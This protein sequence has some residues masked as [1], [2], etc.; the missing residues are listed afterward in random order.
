MPVTQNSSAVN[1]PLRAK[2]GRRSP[3]VLS[4]QLGSRSLTIGLINNMPDAA[5]EATER[6]FISLL[7]A[8]SD[9]ISIRLILYAMPG[10]PRNGFGTQHI[11]KYYCSTDSLHEEK[12]DALIVTGRE[13]LTANLADESYWTSF[14]Q[15]L[16]WA[17][18][19][20]YAVV[21]SCLAAHA[22]VLHMDGVRRVRSERKH[23]GILECRRADE[24][25]LTLGSGRRFAV[26]HSRW[27]GLPEAELVERGYG[28]LSRTADAGVD[29]FYKP[30]KS[31]FLFFQGH[32]EY[33]SMTLLLEYRRDVTRYL[34]AES[35]T[36]PSVPRNYFPGETERALN[37][38]E[39]I[40][41]ESRSE[42]LL[43]ELSRILE[44]TAIENSWRQTGKKIY[45]NWLDY[46]CAQK[47]TQLPA[48]SRPNDH[49]GLE[50]T[51]HIE[52][53]EP[54]TQTSM[55]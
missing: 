39:E 44:S 27:N 37:A 47:R 36:Y 10:V 46:I 3:A 31:L 45:Q 28:V 4:D 43:Q 13:P 6:Q 26:P 14:T 34:R 51:K 21:W 38:L 23:C 48:P 12:V 33:E 22:A 53:A 1:R 20:T 40:A 32:P 55:L 17:Q 52:I 18:E 25:F 7:N 15:I 24:H 11:A 35:D 5:L 30:G 19:N 49:Y 29:A 41:K 42:N 50:V 9:G 2:P 8:A 16:D 54:G